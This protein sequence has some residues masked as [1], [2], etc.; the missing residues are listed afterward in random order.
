MFARFET[1]AVGVLIENICLN[2]FSCPHG[3]IPNTLYG[4]THHFGDDNPLTYF[5]IVII[6]LLIIDQSLSPLRWKKSSS[7]FPQHFFL[8]AYNHASG[9]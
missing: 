1:K 3:S 2:F 7:L 6:F 9:V 4:M 5:E 8:C